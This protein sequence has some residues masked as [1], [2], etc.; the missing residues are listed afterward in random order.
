MTERKLRSGVNWWEVLKQ[1]KR[2]K[3]NSHETDLGIPKTAFINWQEPWNH[4]HHV[5]C[6]GVIW[7]RDP[8]E[9][10]TEVQTTTANQYRNKCRREREVKKEN[11]VGREIK[12]I[13]KKEQEELEAVQISP[14]RSDHISQILLPSSIVFYFNICATECHRNFS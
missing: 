14:G 2:S 9:E 1:I 8:S 12:Q 7:S 6:P 10:E 4:N 11:E 3:I 5:R 13:I